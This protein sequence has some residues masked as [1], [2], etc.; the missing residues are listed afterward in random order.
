MSLVTV[1]S[2][3]Q[4]DG[5]FSLAMAM[6]AAAG[7]GH[8]VRIVNC[9]TLS[10]YAP[11]A[12]AEDVDAVRRI[13]RGE[14]RE[15]ASRIGAP[16]EIVDLELPDAPLR[17]GCPV[18]AVRRRAIGVRERGD[19][20]RIAG[21][22]SGLVDGMLLAPLG[23]GGHIDHLV[24]REA[25]IRMAGAGYSVGF[26]EDLPYAAELRECCIVRAARR[27]A[28]RIGEPMGAALVGGTGGMA[29][30]RFAIAAY[31]SQVAPSQLR[32]VIDYAARRCG[33]ER[34]WMPERMARA[35]PAPVELVETSAAG[36]PCAV[37]IAADR[38]RAVLRRCAQLTLRGGAHVPEAS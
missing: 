33:C 21:A 38:G 11:Y 15:F 31:K 5:G 36:L 34:V 14:D 13:R 2:P 22:L 3:H 9:F 8:R 32:S 20:C 12:A 29:D 27:I 26:F 35:F 17:L 10:G 4:D 18:A 24:A 23:L 37:H 6:R 19:A 30:K 28:D 1:L 7:A 25:G 16:V